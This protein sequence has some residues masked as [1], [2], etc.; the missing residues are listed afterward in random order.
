MKTLFQRTCVISFGLFVIILIG[1]EDK[2]RESTPSPKYDD[3]VW[4]SRPLTTVSGSVDVGA[5]YSLPISENID[6]R[7]LVFKGKDFKPLITIYGSTGKIE[8][9]AGY[10]PEQASKEFL[11]ALAI[12]FPQWKAALKEEK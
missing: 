4:V 2:P 12:A 10:T 7:N 6:S 8:V 11:D 9:G 5:A 1:I 3:K